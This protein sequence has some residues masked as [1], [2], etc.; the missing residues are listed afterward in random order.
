[1]S[2]VRILRGVDWPRVLHFGAVFVRALS[3][4]PRLSADD[5]NA[6]SAAERLRGLGERAARE[7]VGCTGDKSCRC[8]VCKER[9]L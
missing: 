5:Q 7:S 4:D 9:P 1:M 8:A 2:L 6:R 3:E